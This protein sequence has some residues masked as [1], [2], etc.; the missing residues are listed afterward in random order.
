MLIFPEG[1]YS[2]GRALRPLKNGIG[3]F[4]LQAGVPVSPVAVRGTDS[5]WPFHRVEVSIGPPIKPDLPAWWQLSRRVTGMVER[6]RNSIARALAADVP[7]IELNADADDETLSDAIS[8]IEVVIFCAETSPPAHR[9]RF[10]KRPP[11]I[12]SRVVEAARTANV[13]RLVYVSTADVYG[14]DHFARVTEKSALKP[15]HA[16]ERLKLYAE[17]WL[18]ETAH[19]LDVVIV[20]P[21][22]VFGE[23]AD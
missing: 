18:L 12:L 1:R 6:V 2:R 23:G 14:P 10:R 4:A 19:D 7:V 8:G 20:R 9:L 13:R 17:E 5:L 16:Y 21:A 11:H 15:A 3:Y 22:R